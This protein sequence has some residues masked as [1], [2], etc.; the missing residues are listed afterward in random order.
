[1]TD[2]EA[3]AL[4]RRLV[5]CKGFRVLPGMRD[6]QGRY[7]VP[8]ELFY[9]WNEHH[10]P[11]VRDPATRGCLLEL[12]REAWNNPVVNIAVFLTGRVLRF[13]TLPRIDRVGGCASEAEALVAAL[14]AAP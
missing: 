1:M 10:T 12:V 13:S 11:D 14:E 6:M 7:W 2:D 3:Y 5:A 4:G 8:S 9:W